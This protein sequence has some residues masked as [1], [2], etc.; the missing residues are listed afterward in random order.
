M[1]SFAEEKFNSDALFPKHALRGNLGTEPV[2]YI[3]PLPIK[4]I[5]SQLPMMNEKLH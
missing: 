1:T 3:C 4:W 5:K 2:V